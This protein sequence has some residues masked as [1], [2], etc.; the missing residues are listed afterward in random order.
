MTDTQFS[1]DSDM[2]GGS[3]RSPAAF[4][5]ARHSISFLVC[6]LPLASSLLFDVSI[7]CHCC[8]SCS[9]DPFM[10]GLS[11][12]HSTYCV[13]DC[14]ISLCPSIAPSIAWSANYPSPHPSCLK[15]ESGVTVHCCTSC[16]ID[17]FMQDLSSHWS[18][19]CVVDCVISSVYIVVAAKFS[20][21]LRTVSFSTMCGNRGHKQST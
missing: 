15:L 8:T 20:P 17:P 12:Q 2:V 13:V 16:S 3:A 5:S 19:Y 1:S 4:R 7:W 6:Q 14:V 11:S 9:T 21:L 18:T 10:Q